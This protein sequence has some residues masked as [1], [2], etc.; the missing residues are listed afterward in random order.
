MANGDS[1]QQFTPAEFSAK[2]KAK[3]PQYNSIPDDQLV[4]KIVAKY[5]QYKSQ[6]KSDP[7]VT[8]EGMK[9]KAEVPIPKGLQQDDKLLGPHTAEAATNILQPKGTINI[10]GGGKMQDAALQAATMKEYPKLTSPKTMGEAY[11]A[12]LGGAVVG[13]GAGLLMKMLNV[14]S[15]A[16][17]GHMGGSM[18]ESGKPDV[19]GSLETGAGF[20][21]GEGIFGAASK[22]GGKVLERAEPLAR[23]NKLLGVGPKEIRV[24]K[25][26][27]SLDEFSANPARGI[28]KAGITE[29]QLGKMKPLERLQAVTQARDAAGAKLDQVL[30]SPEN[31]GKTIDVS[32]IMKDTFSQI[33]DKRLAKLATT[34]ITQILAKQGIMKPLSQL[35]PM[36][37]RT[38]QRSLDDFANFAPEGTVKSFSDIATS[39]RRG[40]SKA[41][42]QAIPETAELD[43]DYGDLAGAE[44][45]VKRQAN[46]YARTAP[47]SVL[48]KA[49]VAGAGAAGAGMAGAVGYELAKHSILPF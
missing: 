39:L 17:L 30:R 14:G 11:G 5:P 19:K 45:A 37:A 8:G 34:R 43:Q 6:I 38:F 41:T 31:A 10:W 2:I 20:A 9:P 24:G 35:T 25:V 33:P 21:A 28:T 1:P 26:P 47:P 29:K 12:A 3:Y 48:R 7:L 36:E 32:K 44:K 4:S 40:I 23:I 27:E 42:R 22:V 13:P 15:G 49:A 46:K 18:M 16:A